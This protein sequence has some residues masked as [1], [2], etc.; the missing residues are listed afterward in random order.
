MSFVIRGLRA[1]AETVG[2]AI[3]GILKTITETIRP[4]PPPPPPPPIPTLEELAE[5]AGLTPE[6]LIE[7]VLTPEDKVSVEFPPDHEKKLD[8]YNRVIDPRACRKSRKLL[9]ARYGYYLR[10]RFYDKRVGDYRFL[11]HLAL[12][13]YPLSPRDLYER[14]LDL[15]L[16]G[17]AFTEIEYKHEEEDIEMTREMER[18]REDLEFDGLEIVNCFEVEY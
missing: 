12:S 3:T 17:V 5:K 4:P 14:A 15:L 2:R 8:W 9:G 6:K 18:V 13:D 7:S 11:E 16:S 10:I 1:L